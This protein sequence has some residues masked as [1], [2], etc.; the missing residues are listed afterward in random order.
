MMMK[1]PK[2]WAFTFQ[3]YVQLSML[4]N[5]SRSADKN[6]N[7]KVH[8]I[9][10]SIHSARYVFV[11]NH[12]KQKNFARVEYNVLDDFYKLLLDRM[13]YEMC[14]VDYF[15]YLNVS[16][17]NCLQRLAQRLETQG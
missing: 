1:N 12:L 2:R 15:L 17:E 4:N 16:P 5:H 8:L 7:C 10:R 13:N 14:H 6:W 3:N 11:E 9:E